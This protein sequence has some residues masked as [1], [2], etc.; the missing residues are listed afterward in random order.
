MERV[1]KLLEIFF[2]FKI[3]EFVSDKYDE[4]FRCYRIN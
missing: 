1:I 2:C 4:I 3:Y